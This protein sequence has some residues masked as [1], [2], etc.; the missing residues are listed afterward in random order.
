MIPVTIPSKS[1]LGCQ[2]QVD[3]ELFGLDNF[4][5]HLVYDFVFSQQRLFICQKTSHLQ[6]RMAPFVGTHWNLE[7]DFGTSF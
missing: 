5:E 2:Q 3:I 1:F 6:S 7:A 4:G